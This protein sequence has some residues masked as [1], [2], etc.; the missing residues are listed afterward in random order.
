[1]ALPK[2]WLFQLITVSVHAA[3]T[4]KTSMV[5]QAA[6]TAVRYRRSVASRTIAVAG[7]VGLH[8][9]RSNRTY[10]R[11]LAPLPAATLLVVTVPKLLVAEACRTDASRSAV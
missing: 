2:G 6:G 10:K 1:M 7:I 4:G 5:R 3:V 9:E 11:R 8:V